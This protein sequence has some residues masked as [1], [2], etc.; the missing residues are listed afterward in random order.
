MV[1]ASK[2]SA[3]GMDVMVVY[4]LERFIAQIAN[5]LTIVV[6]WIGWLH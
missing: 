4:G 2:G 5:G 6:P 1:F 3:S